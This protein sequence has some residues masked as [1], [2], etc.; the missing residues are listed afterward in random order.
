MFQ[1]VKYFY[2]L[3]FCVLLPGFLPWSAFA[4]TSVETDTLR[5]TLDEAVQ[6]ALAENY[7]LRGT[8]LDIENVSQQIRE[9]WGTVYP[10]VSAVSGYNRSIV[11]A[12]PFA[13]SE[14]G[15]LF[16]S[17]GAIDWISYNENA[18][19]DEIEGDP[20]EFEEFMRRRQNALEEAGV[21]Q[22]ENPFGVDNQF[23]NSLNITQT[24]FNGTAF[25]AIRGA[26]TLRD[27][28]E[29]GL[30]RQTQVTIDEVRTSFYSALLSRQQADVIRSSVERTSETLEETR[31]LV[32]QGVASQQSQLSTEV[33]LVNL[34]TELIDAENQSELASKNINFL[35][36][37]PVEQPVKLIGELE[38]VS[39][40]D[41]DISV[42][43]AYTTA[44]NQRPDIRQAEGGI[45]IS[46]VDIQMTR[47]QYFPVVNAFADL[48]YLGNVPD[49]RTP[50]LTDPQDPFAFSFGDRRSFFADSYWEPNIAVGIQ[51][52]WSIF[53]GGQNRARVQQSQIA[54]RQSELEY[55]QLLNAIRLEV[56]QSM[57]QLRA[58]EKR[59]ESQERNIEQARQ[60][61]D[62]ALSRLREGVGSSL[63]ERQASTLLDQSR[64]GYLSA[65][66]D[67]LNALSSFELAIGE[68]VAEF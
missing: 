41:L 11:T 18:R 23:S 35:L 43:E 8:R 30:E 49:D 2:G 14:A 57:R 51:F 1:S 36:G 34:E 15:G 12:N 46:D 54:L 58:A 6:H 68:S 59:V 48:S 32:E 31:R 22:N 28:N 20:I 37:L 65:I 62:F 16:E 55:E 52:S 33:E 60:N 3:L 21:V 64:L 47:A 66:F 4:Q 38:M 26:E 50:L 53:S 10:Q 45:E 42:D 63:E 61:Y 44:L 40:P 5:L 56:G 9:A 39:I 24:L 25:A 67:Y 27:I 19:L 29:D 7:N 17:F 13:G